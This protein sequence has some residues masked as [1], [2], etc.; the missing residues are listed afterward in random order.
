[1]KAI[2][3][4]SFNFFYKRLVKD[5]IEFE[6]VIGNKITS[7]QTGKRVSI[8]QE[9]QEFF[10]YRNICLLY[11]RLVGE[12][13]GVVLA[14]EGKIPKSI[15]PKLEKVYDIGEMIST[16]QAISKMRDD[17]NPYGSEDYL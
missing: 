14:H 6:Q 2:A 15:K 16:F 13:Q 4:K 3:V 17:N 1:M 8:E 5:V 11:N 10:I 7:V 12:Y 9:K